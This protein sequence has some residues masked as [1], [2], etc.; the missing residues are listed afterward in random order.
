[1][2][3]LVAP[4]CT[5]YKK[6]VAL[7]GLIAKH[8]KEKKERE[9]EI[10]HYAPFFKSMDRILIYQFLFVFSEIRWFEGLIPLEPKPTPREL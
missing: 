7:G 6:N 8:Q 2:D 9:R 1:M 3:K 5:L 10:K 4:E